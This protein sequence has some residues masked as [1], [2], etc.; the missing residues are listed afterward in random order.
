MYYKINSNISILIFCIILFFVVIC[1]LLI[2]SYSNYNVLNDHNY[3]N[4]NTIFNNNHGI[5]YIENIFKSSIFENITNKCKQLNSKL[6]KDNLISGERYGIH[7][8]AGYIQNILNSK[9]FTNFINKIVVNRYNLPLIN[10]NNIKLSNFPIEY[11]VYP[12]KSSGM[13]WHKDTLLYNIP[14]YECVFTIENKSDSNTLWKDE[15]NIIHTI[16]TKPNSIII[17]VADGPT[18][19]V[20]P[21]NNGYRSILKFIFSNGTPI[22]SIVEHDIKCRY[23]KCINDIY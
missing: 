17:V 23:N 11:R 16:K 15:H 22:E 2:N 4:Y 14:Q 20:S 18:H 10:K 5:I 9:Q 7:I 12:T 13:E 1:L 6:T 3:I 19:K 21:I 8:N